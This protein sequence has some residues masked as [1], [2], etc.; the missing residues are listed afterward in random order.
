[1]AQLNRTSQ[2]KQRSRKPGIKN[3]SC[4]REIKNEET[5]L[6]STITGERTG[7]QRGKVH[8]RVGHVLRCGRVLG[9]VVYAVVLM[10]D[11]CYGKSSLWVW[12]DHAEPPNQLVQVCICQNVGE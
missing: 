8:E 6:G 3:H 11:I 5:R 12:T 2:A 4:T 10:L 1:M 9:G 7:D